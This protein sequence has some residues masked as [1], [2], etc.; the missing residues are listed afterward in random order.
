MHYQDTL[1]QE[2]EV[3]L[4]SNCLSLRPS[5]PLIR[6]TSNIRTSTSPYCIENLSQPTHE[7]AHC[8]TLSSFKHTHGSHSVQG[9]DRPELRGTQTG[10]CDKV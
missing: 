8:H 9:R 1:S 2:E 10:G 4:G 6:H 5:I 3:L 7:D